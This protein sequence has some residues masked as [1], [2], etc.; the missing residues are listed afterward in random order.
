MQTNKKVSKIIGFSALFNNNA[1][2]YGYGLQCKYNHNNWGDSVME[3]IYQHD[4]R[5]EHKTKLW[6]HHKFPIFS[7]LLIPSIHVYLYIPYADQLLKQK[8]KYH[9][10]AAIIFVILNSIPI[11]VILISTSKAIK[12]GSW[13]FNKLFF[14]W[15]GP[16]VP[17][18]SNSRKFVVSK[19]V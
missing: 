8:I 1:W 7:W 17:A 9:I 14:S 2:H 11:F 5:Y 3:I 19:T 4:K 6:I 15:I 12:G 18:R 10:M 16:L 13:L